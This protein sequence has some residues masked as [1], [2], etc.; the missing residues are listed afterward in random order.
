MTKRWRDVLQIHPAAELFPLMTPDEL[1]ALGEDIKRRGGLPAVP[2]VL[3]E[4]EKN[5][6]QFLLDGR[7]RLDAMEAAGLPVLDKDGKDLDWNL[8]LQCTRL[9]GGDP[10][11]IDIPEWHVLS[12]LRDRCWYGVL[13]SKRPVDGKILQR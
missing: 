7:N 9:R 13:S 1:H 6:Q 10:Y 3:W 12:L 5:A 8:S 2:L 11:A 4:A